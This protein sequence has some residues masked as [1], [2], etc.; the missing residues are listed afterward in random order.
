MNEFLP[1]LYRLCQSASRLPRED[2]LTLC[3]GRQIERDAALTASLF[4]PLGIA[5][6]APVRV[7]AQVRAW[8][9]AGASLVVADLVIEADEGVVVLEAKVGPAVPSEGQLQRLAA[10][11][12]GARILSLV[13]ASATARVPPGAAVL[14]WDDVLRGLSPGPDGDELRELLRSSG[15]GDT[16]IG[17]PEDLWARARRLHERYEAALRPRLQ[18]CLVALCPQPL[19]DAVEAALD[20]PDRQVE[21]SEGWGPGFASTR[22]LP[23]TGVKGLCLSVDLGEDEE[24]VWKLEVL[25]GRALAKALE[26][27]GSPWR[28]VPSTERW[29]VLELHRSPGGRNLRGEDLKQVVAIGRAAL[30]HA[31]SGVLGR[32]WD[33]RGPGM[34]PSAPRLSVSELVRG[35][36]A[37]APLEA[38]LSGCV[39]EVLHRVFGPL[40][41][42]RAPYRWTR[43]ARL[44]RKGLLPGGQRLR[45]WVEPDLR[46]LAFALEPP[47]APQAERFLQA[48]ASWPLPGPVLGW[49]GGLRVEL[50]AETWAHP[51]LVPAIVALLGE[52]LDRPAPE[53]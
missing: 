53:A 4:R 11:F 27:S 41:G 31:H 29:F 44:S 19:A 33:V 38:A 5:P 20:D 9:E 36:S 50:S 14:S 46:T 13:E 8:V 22:P 52:I 26:R 24:L 23:R 47:S 40:E 1:R 17:L 16:R 32:A 15:V 10:A 43:D 37:W 51:G 42:G 49:E 6:S 2:F 45:A 18:T 3:L 48:L 30:R 28:R 12:P 21:P 7:R 35:L 34:A 39:A 25:A